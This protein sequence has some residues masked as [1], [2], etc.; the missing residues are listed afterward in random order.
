M[1]K[2]GA[3]PAYLTIGTITAPFA[4]KGE[5]KVYPH[6][7]FPERF[8]ALQAVYL[9]GDG[10]PRERRR[11]AGARVKGGV[12]FLKL[13]GVDSRAGAEALRNVDLLVPREE[14]WQLPEDHYYRYQLIGLTVFDATGRRRGTLTKVYPGPANDFFAVS[15]ENGR[16]TL[17]PAIR[18]VVTAVDLDEGRLTVV[19]PEYY[20]SRRGDGLGGE[21]GAD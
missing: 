12:V 10:Q 14:A 8:A 7:D 5:V 13:V 18:A 20:E 21:L 3:P 2:S 11:V 16:E 15:D 17:L 4:T 19:W 9:G 1:S 6:T